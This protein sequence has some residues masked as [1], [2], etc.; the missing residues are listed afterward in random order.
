[1]CCHCSLGVCVHCERVFTAN[2]YAVQEMLDFSQ[3]RRTS[4]MEALKHAY[5][6]GYESE[7]SVY[8]SVNA[9]VSISSSNS[10]TM[11]DEEAEDPPLG[12]LY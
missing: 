12:T 9:N 10:D 3:S 5:F 8:G 11:V 7:H 2:V 4:A 1:M 6:S